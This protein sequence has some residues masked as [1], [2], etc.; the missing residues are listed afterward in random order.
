MEVKNL[1]DTYSEQ[2]ILTAIRKSVTGPAAYTLHNLLD[3]STLNVLQK[4]RITYGNVQPIPKVKQN[5]YSLRQL[6]SESITSFAYRLD[7]I[8]YTLIECGELS[9]Q[10][11]QSAAAERF[12][13]GLLPTFQ[14]ALLFMKEKPYHELLE[15]ARTLENDTAV[16]ANIS[17]QDP[18]ET[19]LKVLESE[20]KNL[21]TDQQSVMSKL[22][23]LI[24]RSTTVHTPEKTITCYQCHKP[25][26]MKKN[27]PTLRRLNFSRR[28]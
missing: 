12:Y 16:H 22:D 6:P 28:Q 2:Q 23:I 8:L 7:N 5:F 1:L 18:F 11:A 9:K 14:S 26:H 15:M 17:A 20:V 10:Q 24:D 21:K 3:P 4:F 25:G 19:R 13:Y 27:C